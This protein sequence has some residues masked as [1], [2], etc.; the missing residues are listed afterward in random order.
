MKRHIN[1][2]MLLL[3]ITATLFM[4][5]G[6]SKKGQK[7]PVA[8]T[9][10]A[11]EEN[12]FDP[13]DPSLLPEDV[14]RVRRGD[15]LAV[16]FLYNP[17]L[18]IDSVRV[19]D[20]GYVTF[21]VI[22]DVEVVGKTANE[23][24]EEVRGLYKLWV[25]K[26]GYGKYMRAGDEIQL[27]FTY[28]PHLNQRTVVRPDGKVSLLKLREVQAEGL[29]FEQFEK[30]V[31]EG[32][33]KYIKDLEMSLYLLNSRTRKLYTA[34]G[35]ITVIVTNPQPK[36]IFVGGEVFKPTVISFRDWMTPLQAL[37]M[38]GGLKDSANGAGVVYITRDKEGHALTA[39]LD[40]DDYL[41]KGAKK[42]LYLRHGDI[43]VVPR[44]GI[45]R[46]NLAVRQYIRDTLPIRTHF[47]FTYAVD[48]DEIFNE[49]T[50]QQQTTQEPG[51]TQQ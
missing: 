17:E 19:R 14:Y 28:N 9:E 50:E 34:E 13:F 7:P 42:N 20:D 11:N 32:Y 16:R 38:A 46:L 24:T 51:E 8:E 6:C 49:G 47:A 21:P 31:F 18:N 25:E 12:E 3:L 40:L 26:S 27:R 37:S 39:W 35:N 43:L 15:Q 33:S 41:R 2:L 29:T 4:F 36:E 1:I 5:T 22:N 48:D 10:V 30:N 23:L 45:A 44:S